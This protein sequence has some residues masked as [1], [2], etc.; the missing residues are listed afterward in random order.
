MRCDFVFVLCSYYSIAS[1]GFHI[2]SWFDFLFPVLINSTDK[3]TTGDGGKPILSQV[4]FQVLPW[5]LLDYPF[6]L[7]CPWRNPILQTPFLTTFSRERKL[8]SYYEVCI[9]QARSCSGSWSRDCCSTTSW[10]LSFLFFF[11]IIWIGGIAFLLCDYCDKKLT[12][13]KTKT[14]ASLFC[15]INLLIST[16]V[17]A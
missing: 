7:C 15:C 1:V 3:H 14:R 2:V 17:F 5:W 8:C 11:W 13:Q 4:V 10:I 9:N 16:L 6:K 12:P